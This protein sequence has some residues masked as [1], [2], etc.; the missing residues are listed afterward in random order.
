MRTTNRTLT[1]ALALTLSLTLAA[2]G[3]ADEEGAG[4]A[5]EQT[6]TEQ[7]TATMAL[8]QSAT[9]CVAA[10]DFATDQCTLPTEGD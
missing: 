9:D 8:I 7:T 3:S 2:C 6:T 10:P 5:P 4:V 1:A